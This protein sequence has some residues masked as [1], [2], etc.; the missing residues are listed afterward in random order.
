MDLL[1]KNLRFENIMF[2]FQ[3]ITTAKMKHLCK[4]H[5]LQDNI[6]LIAHVFCPPQNFDELNAF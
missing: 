4:Y 2:V 5:I 3:S 6:Q 1:L